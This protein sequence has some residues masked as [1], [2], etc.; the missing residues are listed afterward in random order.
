MDNRD[1]PVEVRLLGAAEVVVDGR[2]VEVGSA[3]QLALLIALALDAGTVVST[4]RLV[5]ALWGEDPP[6]TAHPT[7]R[8]LVYR[9]RK[10]LASDGEEAAPW[11]RGKGTGYVLDLGPDQIDAV[12]F[13]RL[14]ATGRDALARADVAGAA[15]ALREGLA[16]WRGPALD[17]LAGWPGFGAEARRFHEA[18]LG[19]TEDL[20]AAELGLDRPGDALARLE[21][22]VAAN[23]LRERAWGQ[24]MLA[25]YR[26]GRQA[27]AL[28][29]YQQVRHVLAEELGLEPTPALHDLEAGILQHRPDLLL[30]EPAI[31][32]RMASPARSRDFGDTVAFLFTDIESSTRRGED[33]Q[34][35]MA[36]DLARHDQLLTE[37]CAGWDGSVFSH[38]GDG[39]RAAFPT[40][41]APSVPPSPP[42]ALSAAS[43]G[44]GPCGC[45][46]RSTPVRPNAGP[47]TISARPST[48]PLASWPVPGAARSSVPRPLPTWRPTSSPGQVTLLDLGDQR[49]ADLAHPE[50][51][52]Q[53]V[54]PG[55]HADF[56]PLRTAGAPHHNLPAALTSFVGRADEID[57]VV[58]HLGRSRL[59][60]LVGSG[61]AGKTRLA[62]EA[63]AA[64]LE[65]F[66]DGAWLV[67]LAPVRNPSL[68]A[69]EV[70]AAVG[71]DPSALAGSGHTFDTALCD[72][73]R[74]R[75]L[76]IVLDNC[77]HLV[78]AAAGLAHAILIQLSG[79][80]G[81]GHES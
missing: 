55:L 38:T 3:K 68:V 41:A 4:E 57:A 74:H 62:L 52:F 29:A 13:E 14:A 9:L 72:E 54:H 18:R 64:V 32:A 37:A 75:R 77:E 80:R 17:G 22:H 49:L 53:V 61:G 30:G 11:L 7:L 40:A 47:A 70:A 36:A 24:L 26:L 5:E 23:P 69:H 28:R 43:I 19:A 58:G 46:W 12:R 45:G 71:L 6:E 16:L 66:P 35:A 25:L 67:D 76:L 27:E 63:A 59:V 50:R 73:L 33:D 10:T 1:H 34:D 48:G 15:D 42:R 2:V 8:G 31:P 56:P 60:T 51:I 78:A 65:R 44:N 20:A 21:P 79:H 39:L 81:V